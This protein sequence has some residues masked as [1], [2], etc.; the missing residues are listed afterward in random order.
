VHTSYQGCPIFVKEARAINMFVTGIAPGGTESYSTCLKLFKKCSGTI[1]DIVCIPKLHIL[2]GITNM[3]F[4][5]GLKV[6]P[7]MTVWPKQFHIIHGDYHSQDFEGNK[8]RKLLRSCLFVV[9]AL[10]SNHMVWL[11]TKQRIQ[12]AIYLYNQAHYNLLWQGPQVGHESMKL[13]VD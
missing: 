5:E 9:S 7:E 8:A 3:M 2:I 1:L 12:I 11:P 4:K 10:V 6:W 13:N